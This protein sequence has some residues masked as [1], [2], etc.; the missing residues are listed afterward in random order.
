[1][2]V[3]YARICKVCLT[4]FTPRREQGQRFCS[5][6]CAA[7]WVGSQ[8]KGRPVGYSHTPE[9]R[10]K[11]SGSAKRYLS[12]PEGKASRSGFLKGRKMGDEAKA[13]MSESARRRWD[14]LQGEAWDRQMAHLKNI[15]RPT[16]I[17][18]I[19]VDILLCDFPE[20]LREEPFGRYT[21]DAYLPHPYHLAFEADGVYWH[22]DR[23]R[24]VRRDKIL[25][26]EHGLIVIRFSERELKEIQDAYSV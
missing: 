6:S 24:D 5:T 21:V 22:R 3:P 12:T 8:N 11:M 23:E 13:R 16:S 20:V 18:N 10:A 7:K 1:M 9:T 4:S 17:E 15:Q 19:L 2:S 25:L 26:E 14:N